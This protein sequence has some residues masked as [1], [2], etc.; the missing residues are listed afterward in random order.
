MTPPN[1]PATAG[2]PPDRA[3][4]VLLRPGEPPAAFRAATGGEWPLAVAHAIASS[5]AWHEHGPATI[6]V[7]AGDEPRFGIAGRFD[8]GA[9]RALDG[10]DWQLRHAL[11]VLTYLDYAKVER[12][13]ERLATSLVER[14]GVNA[15]RA[16]RFVAVPRGGHVVLGLLAYALGIGQE[17]L[18]RSAHANDLVIVV[19]DVAISGSRFRRCVDA[20]PSD[21]R[22]AFAPLVS[23][24]SLRAAVEDDPRVLACVSGHDLHDFAPEREGAGY[25]AWVERWRARDAAAGY[26]AGQTDHVC[27]PWNEPDITHWNDVTNREERGWRLV[28]PDL[29]MKHRQPADAAGPAGHGAS[30]PDPPRSP[31]VRVHVHEQGPGPLHPANDVL[32]APFEETYLLA[33]PRWSACLALEG[34]GATMWRALVRHGRIDLA[35][36]DVASSTGADEA[37]VRA[38]LDALVGA[39]KE[40]GALSG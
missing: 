12:T 11:P 15:M 5:P 10:L 30:P 19:D 6:V 34:V 17:Q 40:R 29:C 26:W 14:L 3:T 20:L 22:V 28:P 23:H 38:D 7:G 24:P 18:A 1:G 33:S 32:A 36:A 31:V 13:V 27:F 37:V 2:G 16:A 35:S 21:G 4:M 9:R 39:L 8:A 25:A